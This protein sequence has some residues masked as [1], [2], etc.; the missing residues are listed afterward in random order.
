MRASRS[1]PQGSFEFRTWGGVRRGAGPK[2]QRPR[3]GVPHRPRPELRPYQP[4]HVTLRVLEHVWN[5]RSERSFAIVHRAVAAIRGRNDF[6]VVHFSTQ[7][8]HL[9]LIVEADGA[10]ALATGMRALSI[11]IARGLNA[12][13]GRDGPVYE[14]RYHAHVLATRAEV[15]N[16]VRYVLGNF[17][18]HARRRGEPVREGFVDRFSSAAT[19]PPRSGQAS[20]WLEPITRSPA[21]W[22]LGTTGSSPSVPRADAER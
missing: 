3:P 4:V 15:R 11:R 19:S 14:D 2:R 8:N 5:L 9:H 10:R 16:A 7:G 6:R 22:L 1:V 17:A 21:T 20:L 12:M 13:M 18:S